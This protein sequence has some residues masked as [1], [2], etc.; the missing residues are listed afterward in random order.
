MKHIKLFEAFVASQKLN[1]SEDPH[2]DMSGV[3]ISIKGTKLKYVYFDSDMDYSG[4]ICSEKDI[5][6]LENFFL[7]GKVA[8][9]KDGV[10]YP[11]EMGD[12]YSEYSQDEDAWEKKFAPVTKE[13]GCK[14]SDLVFLELLHNELDY[15]TEEEYEQAFDKRQSTMKDT[16]KKKFNL[17]SIEE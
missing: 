14:F 12:V 5:P 6:S 17:N 15:Y 3:I 13:L 1:E 8:S 7:D 4:I 10:K 9:T 2:G 16:T 11:T